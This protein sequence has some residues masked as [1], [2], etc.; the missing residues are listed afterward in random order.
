LPFAVLWF[1][2]SERGIIFVVLMGSTVLDR[3]VCAAGI[4]GC[5][6]LLARA[7][8]TLG[9]SKLQLYRYVVIPGDD[10]RR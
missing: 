3:N 9:A 4:A 8:G 10:S 6:P 5:P 1:G 7:A 2:L